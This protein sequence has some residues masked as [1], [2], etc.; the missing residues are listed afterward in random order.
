MKNLDEKLIPMLKKGFCT[1]Q[2]AQIA[3]TIKEPSTT[4]HFNVK[5]LEKEGK[6]KGYKAVF[7]YT[8]IDEGFCGFA[9]VS[10]S[11]D[12]YGNPEILSK[13]IANNPEVESVDICTGDWEL[14]V[15]LRA[16]DQT[17]YF[18]AIK[19]IMSKKGIAKVKSLVSLKSIKSEFIEI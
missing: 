17:E 14:V 12:T 18:S 3:R 10:L 1:P 13:S 8:K 5:K 11:P 4:I 16:K 9:L 2:I 19:R 6:I 7:D 15:K